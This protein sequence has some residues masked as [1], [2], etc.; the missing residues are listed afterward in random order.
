MPTASPA[1][2]DTDHDG[3]QGRTPGGRQDS[4]WWEGVEPPQPPA[5]TQVPDLLHSITHTLAETLS[6]QINKAQEFVLNIT[7]PSSSSSSSTISSSTS[8][9]SS[10][11]TTVPDSGGGG[12]TAAGESLL[13]NRTLNESSE[14]HPG[15]SNFSPPWNI[16]DPS[17]STTTSFPG[18]VN[19]KNFSDDLEY[20]FKEFDFFSNL[21]DC[22]NSSLCWGAPNATNVTFKG[23]PIDIDVDYR[24][25]N[26]WNLL[27][28][29]FPFFTLFGNV[30]VCV[31]VYR[32]RTLRTVTNYFIVSLA[33]AD[34]MVGLLVMPLAVYV[35]VSNQLL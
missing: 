23:S 28:L 35:E 3:T 18:F 22:W 19:I 24:T 26:Y 25:P 32:E 20:H 5:T 16:A 1:Y 13:F 8:L 27:L 4:G 30:L 33:I 15:L 21:T 2:P 9:S 6:S 17:H 29:I 12:G 11:S 34:I 31:S 7:T 14:Y 10:I